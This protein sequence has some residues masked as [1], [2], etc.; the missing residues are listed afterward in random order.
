MKLS[1]VTICRNA[2]G[3]LQQTV[4]SVLAQSRL[5]DEYLIQDGASTDGSLEGLL[6]WLRPLPPT[7]FM[8]VEANVEGWMA[9]IP[10]QLPS[11]PA[12]GRWDRRV[13]DCEIWIW[14][15]PDGGIYDA[16]NRGVARAAGDVI[17]LLHA[18]DVYAH[19]AV[20]ANVMRAFEAGADVVYGDLQYVR[21]TSDG[22]IKVVRHWRSGV[23][24]P[25]QL[26]W[27]WMP[28]H[29]ALFVRR[30]MYERLAL[31]KNVYFD[32][33]YRCAGDY[34]FILRLFKRLCVPPVYLPEVLVRMRTGGI[35]NRSAGHIMRKSREDWRA[36]R[37]NQTGGLLT[38]LAKNL[39]KVGQFRV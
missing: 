28:P 8:P 1:V 29:P 25:R 14:S 38:L 16:L 20:L 18:D 10:T 30:D 15:E 19:Q 26:A 23:Y 12:Q 5:P 33:E 9:S 35:S 31:A 27:G 21:A 2:G 3:S 37:R 6:D 17:G 22:G 24:R 4:E 39:R 32:P 36:I 13:G 34:D 7:G 11:P